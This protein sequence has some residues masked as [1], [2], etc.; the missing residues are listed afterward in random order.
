M[1]RNVY[2]GFCHYIGYTRPYGKPGQDW[3][4]LVSRVQSSFSIWSATHPCPFTRRIFFNTLHFWLGLLNHHLYV[5]TS[6]YFAQGISATSA[7]CSTT[8][9]SNL[10]WSALSAQRAPHQIKKLPI[11]AEMLLQIH[12]SLPKPWFLHIC[13]ILWYVPQ[14]SL[15]SY[16]PGYVWF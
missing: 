1:H 13:L 2:L 5:P 12:T 3:T 10:Y 7:L 15:A 14:G 9:P 11:T 16:V 6:T 4:G 8:G